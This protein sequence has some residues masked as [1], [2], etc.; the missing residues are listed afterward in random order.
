MS[1][2]AIDNV[3][4]AQIKAREWDDSRHELAVL[5]TQVGQ[6]GLAL[7]S[8]GII[9]MQTDPGWLLESFENIDLESLR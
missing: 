7:Q 1:G 8:G 4:D 6:H 5:E 3:K 9:P 2:D